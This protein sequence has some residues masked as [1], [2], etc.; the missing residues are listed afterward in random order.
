MGGISVV[1]Y[2]KGGIIMKKLTR[3]FITFAVLMG[4]NMQTVF[5]YPKPV[6]LILNYN[7]LIGRLT[8]TRANGE[9]SGSEAL[10]YKGD[11]ITG[12]L[13]YIKFDFAPCADFYS[14]GQA[15]VITHNPPSGFDG[16]VQ[17]AIDTASS[18]W[19]NVE[20]VV[21]GASRG[22]SEDFNL[23]PQP[24]FE[25]TLFLNQ[26]V[27]FAW[28]GA[29]NKI[30]SIKDYKGN[31]IFEEK[32]TGLSYIEIIPNEIKLKAGQSYIWNIDGDYQDYKF[33]VLDER[34]EDIILS[35]LAEFDT[36]NI[37]TEEKILKKAVYLQLISD[38]YP[39]KLDLYWLS[40]QWITA[41]NP[42]TKK[43][44]ELKYLL[45]K[46]CVQNLDSKM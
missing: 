20:T 6:A 26:S 1:R 13:A 45:L 41:L 39:D 12:D 28:D 4:L 15:Y 43:V 27:R 16:I 10:L 35:K 44:E 25:V 2:L 14:N 23:N 33:T 34:T 40:T 36:E 31:K 42:K 18:F 8:I 17:S 5:A 37:S 9:P 7:D 38:I 19:N 11:Q 32:I 22:S 3:Y 24:G 21:S 30:F 29:D 46:K